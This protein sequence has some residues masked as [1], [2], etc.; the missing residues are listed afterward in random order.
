MDAFLQ[1]CR[2]L[3]LEKK[4]RQN[5]HRI[6]FTVIANRESFGCFTQTTP[7]HF[8]KIENP[9]IIFNSMGFM[10]EF[11]TGQLCPF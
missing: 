10:F 8:L 1:Y 6:I 7:G 5:L 3:R 2:E 9:V 4:H 11:F